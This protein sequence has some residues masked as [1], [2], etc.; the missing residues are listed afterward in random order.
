M[1][2]IARK[3]LVGSTFNG[4][5]THQTFDDNLNE[6]T[7]PTGARLQF[8]KNIITGSFL[9]TPAPDA[10]IFLYLFSHNL[11]LPQYLVDSQ[12]WCE[13]Y[14]T[15]ETVFIISK[16]T[17]SEDVEIGTIAFYT[18][19]I[20]ISF[21]QDINFFPGDILAITAPSA[22][23][24]I[25]NI[26][27][28]IHGTLTKELIATPEEYFDF[29]AG[30]ITGYNLDGGTDIIIPATIG[31]IPVTTIAADAFSAATQTTGVS[32]TEGLP[33]TKVSNLPSYDYAKVDADTPKLTSVVIPEGI[34][35]IGERAFLDNEIVNVY[36][37]S[38]LTTISDSAFQN[39]LIA[40]MH[41]PPYIGNIGTLAFAENKISSVRIPSTAAIGHQAF[42]S[43]K[44]GRLSSIVFED[45]PSSIGTDSFGNNEITSITINHGT[46]INTGSSMGNYGDEFKVSYE[47]NGQLPGVYKYIGATWTRVDKP[48]TYR[49]IY[50]PQPLA[51][52]TPLT[53]LFD[54]NP[55]FLGTIAWT[56]NDTTFVNETIY[57]ATITLQPKQGYT[58]TGVPANFFKVHY[59][60]APIKSTNSASSAEINITFPETSYFGFNPLTRAITTY[61]ESGSSD[62]NIPSY[63]NG[64]NVDAIQPWAFY[65]KGIT[66]ANGLIGIMEIGD[67]CF[68][69]NLLTSI[70]LS[71]GV[72]YIP[73]EAFAHN[74][75]ISV[76]IPA[77]V[78]YIHY[79]AFGDNQI[80]SLIL[81]NNLL[82]IGSSAFQNNQL[83]SI[84]IPNSV[85][86]ID[87][88][89]FYNNPI[90][91]ITIGDNVQINAVQG[92][93]GNNY[94]STFAN[95]YTGAAGTFTY[96][97]STETWVRT[98]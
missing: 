38:T 97:S 8:E 73:S 20:N 54:D 9:G 12:F 5:P 40:Y 76:A 45:I 95:A 85:Q 65:N 86:R 68:K 42:Y 64:V 7:D 52:Q 4:M 15:M 35:S 10:K 91:I 71:S 62:I 66:S 46:T 59:G 41:L 98:S 32:S 11:Q 34:V 70:N 89:A 51:G 22:L 28:N 87:A 93:L 21:F 67:G 80:S 63:V 92:T 72:R 39:N 55:Q 29:S 84:I 78:E 56:P 23:N 2:L 61:S 24:D 50:L 79:A 43:Q 6:L 83:T 74:Q 44:D 58:V 77:A 19:S 27:W 96:N 30:T 60:G 3:L 26:T 81:N 31:G 16:I 48:I 57:T 25:A 94:N 13:T 82:Q 47:F 49:T 37:P 36:L 33:S 18:D 17:G 90:V 69:N 14:P 53:T 1:S 88:Y 75:L